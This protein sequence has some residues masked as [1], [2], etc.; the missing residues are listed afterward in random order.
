MS[1][2]PLVSIITIVY[3]GERF[4]N[5]CIDSIKDQSYKNIEYIVIDGGSKDG[6][7]DI[8]KT[9]GDLVKVLVS[10]K[11]EGISDAFNKGI[12]KATGEIIG[13]LNSD[14]FFYPDT[15]ETVVDFYN[16]NEQKKGIYFGDIRYFDDD[17]SYI[18]ISDLSKMWKYM[19]LN[20]P[21]VFVTSNVYKEIGTF[22]KEY[23]YTMDVEFLHRALSKSVPFF[24]INKS[25]ANFRLEG[26][27]DLHYKDM[28]KE[29]YKSVQK[30]ND[31]GLSTRFW[32]RWSVFKKDVA[33]TSIG[34]FFYKRKHLLTPLLSGKIAK[35]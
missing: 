17:M 29:F 28:Y 34:K 30:Y 19:S 7:I 11:D 25:L 12:D 32:Y 5:K 2:S 4:L 16:N 27:S 23:K 26:T 10:E 18:R 21:S 35:G 1:A 8:V 22:S 31:Q 14:D 20:H 9:Y 3:N 15:I 33:Q 13:I 6:T 24:Y